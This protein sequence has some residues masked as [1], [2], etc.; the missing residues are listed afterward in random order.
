MGDKVADAGTRLSVIAIAQDESKLKAAK[1]ARRGRAFKLLWTKSS[2]AEQAGIAKFAVE[3]DLPGAAGVQTKKGRDG[4][5]VVGF[6][7]SG[8]VFYRISVPAAKEEEVAAMVKLQAEA[9]LPLPAE[10]MELAWRAG[11]VED[12]QV[13]VTVAAARKEQLQGLVE[14]VRGF[15]PAKILLD[16]EG[17]VKAWRAFFSGND[18]RAVVVSMGERNTQVCLAEGGRLINAVGLDIGME[19]FSGAEALAE[20]T[21]AAER[22][23]QDVRSVL[24]L[25]GYAEATAVPVFVLSDGG[26]V[27]ES[28]VSCL[29]SAGLKA[30][31]ALPDVEKLTAEI[32]V[33]AEDIYEY[34]VPIGLASMVLD[35]DAEELNVFERLYNPAKKE[36]KKHWYYSAKV[37]GAIAVVML[38]LLG[39]VFCSTDVA[40]DKRLSRLEAKTGFKELVQRQ[41]L[42]KAVARHRQ[43]SDVLKLLSTINSVDSKGI[44]L[45]SF[46]F[47]KGEPARLTGQ[48]D[49]TEQLG[50]FEKNLQDK[51]DISNVT[52]ESATQDEKGKKIIFTIKFD[53]KSFSKKK[54][55]V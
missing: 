23:A 31:T 2:E 3:C 38:V 42:V 51:K 55:R 48:A 44:L 24:E 27:I 41:R 15:E 29:G 5:A 37:T 18:E 50:K 43:R 36:V 16:C 33:G 32:E 6:E 20:H 26:S 21:E 35:G 11:K 19:D 8:A 53:Y 45:N 30:E 25:F 28:I 1:L 10:Q 40:G 39:V 17:I 54:G 52:E 46:H 34:R 47:G 22:F 7:S 13:A 49:N 4:I 9:R 14:N 12:G